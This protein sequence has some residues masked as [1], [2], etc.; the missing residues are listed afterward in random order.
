MLGKLTREPCK[1]FALPRISKST[2][3]NITRAQQ[4]LNDLKAM[5]QVQRLD[6]SGFKDT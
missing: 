3:D 1:C 5:E 4:Y 6:G 2:I